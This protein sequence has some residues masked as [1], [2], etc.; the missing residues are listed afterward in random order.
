M[1]PG[2]DRVLKHPLFV[3]KVGGTLHIAIGASYENCFVEDPSSPEGERAIEQLERSG[4]LNRSAQH[5]DIVTD[6]RPG[7]VGRRVLLDETEL[8]VRDGVWALPE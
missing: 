4:A 1:N 5:V 7:G 2:L 3:E 6:F 8:C